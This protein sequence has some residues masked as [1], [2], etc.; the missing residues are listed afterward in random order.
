MVV[1]E[2]VALL[3]IKPDSGSFKKAEGNMT[4]L[5]GAVEAGV[6][7]TGQRVSV[8]KNIFGEVAK[9]WK[10]LATSMIGFFAAFKVIEGIKDMVSFASDANETL[11]VLDAAFKE[12]QSAVKDW[13]ASFAKEAG[14][15][16]FAM[17]E[18]AATLG[19][20]LT[21]MMDGNAE[22]SAKMSMGLGQLVVDLGSFFNAAEPDVLMALRS[23]ITGEAEPLKRFGVVL[24]EATLKQYAHS[25]GITKSI[26]KMTN[27]EK[28]ALRYGYIMEATSAAQGD[29]AKTAGGWANATKALGAM[30][31]DIM[32]T[33][34][35]RILPSLEK[36][37]KG[38]LGVRSS[39]EK[40]GIFISR[41]VGFFGK[42]IGVIASLV[43]RLPSFIKNWA[44]VGVALYGIIKLLRAGAWGKWAI[45]I[46]LVLLIVE[47]L[48]AYLDGAPSVIG[49]F[50]S[51]LEDMTGIDITG[52]I[53]AAR[54]GLALFLSDLEA[55]GED[56]LP[57]WEKLWFEV[58]YV[59]QDAVAKMK[60]WWSTGWE[61]FTILVAAGMEKWKEQFV[62]K[63]TGIKN[64]I[65]DNFITPVEN[66]I[67]RV[68]GLTE[69]LPTAGGKILQM[70][71]I[72][73]LVGAAQAAQ[74][75][76]GVVTVGPGG[77]PSVTQSTNID[78]SVNAG[79]G[80]NEG[81][82]AAEVG[83]QVKKQMDKVNRDAMGAF[84]NKSPIPIG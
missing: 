41:I 8:L 78:V 12:N 24:N 36:M 69:K 7:R 14:R 38:M 10:N 71:N 81:Q 32:T 49:N 45:L 29:A 19:A 67:N 75:Q 64:W 54:E 4:K 30:F 39:F 68:F 28:T 63:L 73:A 23:G 61:T 44:A 5:T 83:R 31:R 79:P 72:G 3:G 70:P 66:A 58:A 6:Q 20:V 2:L 84:T 47:D 55:A 53:Q 15:S 43:F 50:I 76:G 60:E 56:T 46:G 65:V 1:R 82:L 27:A 33:I 52:Y 17:R 62:E 13:A 42:L 35:L 59:V 77:S 34:G 57:V 9:S 80:M 22:A 11:N 40:A 21:P 74:A 18:N 51:A 16:E 37:V 25:Q 48:M 26:Q